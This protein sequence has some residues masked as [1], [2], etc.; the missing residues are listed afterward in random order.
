MVL[1]AT[2]FDVVVAV[3]SNAVVV[4]DVL[5]AGGAK[6]KKHKRHPRIFYFPLV[7]RGQALAFSPTH[8]NDQTHHDNWRSLTRCCRSYSVQEILS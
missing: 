5:V 1:V 8:D 7:L 6:S 2:V 4:V 3:I